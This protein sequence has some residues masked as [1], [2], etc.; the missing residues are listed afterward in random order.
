[1]IIKSF[2]AAS[3]AAA[4]KKVRQE[5]GGEAIVLKTV[6]NPNAESG[7]RVEVTACLENPSAGHMSLI[8][9][10][11]DEKNR[12]LNRAG[13]LTRQQEPQTEAPAELTNR[14]ASLESRIEQL[15]EAGNRPEEGPDEGSSTDDISDYL[16]DCDF[17]RELVRRLTDGLKSGAHA[18]LR[19]Q[20]LPRLVDRFAA[21]TQPNI[22]FAPGDRVALVGPAGCGKSSLLGK[23]AA[24]LVALENR[25]VA[26]KSL[27]SSKLA[28]FDEIA[29]YAE[30]LGARL[31]DPRVSNTGPDNNGGEIIL[32]DTP[33]MPFDEKRRNDLVARVNLLAPTHVIGVM[34]I[35]T[36]TSDAIRLGSGMAAFGLTG[37]AITMLDL[38]HRYGSIPALAETTGAKIGLVS[39]SPSGAGEVMTPDPTR[40]AQ[41]VLGTEVAHE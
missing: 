7:A 35:L 14:L 41:T 21:A 40:L 6:Q 39:S 2:V 1:M 33:A 19:S 18:H 13:R 27:D 20:I 4:L 11:P 5:M 23:L 26:L 16:S 8:L 17:P 37:L 15:L 31:D 34:S 12:L 22:E 24:R 32:I 29:G 25:K 28:A 36:R 30:A 3:S 9:A 38:T 10:Q